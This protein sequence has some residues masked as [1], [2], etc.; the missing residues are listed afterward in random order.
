MVMKF[1]SSSESI[2]DWFLQRFFFFFVFLLSCTSLCSQEASVQATINPIEIMIGEQA[3][4]EVKAM[5]KEG[6][7]SVFPVFKPN[8]EIIPGVEVID[9]KDGGVHNA[10][11]GYVE[12]TVTYTITSFDDTLYYLPPFEVKIGGKAFKSKSLALKV[13][14]LDVDTLH[15]ENFFGPK[16]VQSNPFLWSEWK[17]PFW[18]SVLLLLIMVVCY[19]LYLRLRDNKP[20]I[21]SISFVKRILPHQRAINEIEELRSGHRHSDDNQEELKNYYTKLTEALR[22]YIEERYGFSAMEMT[23]SEIIEQ[24]M[25]SA[26]SKSLDEL[27]HVFQTADLVKFAKYST[28]IN[29]NDANLV[30]ALEFINE[31]KR[32]DVQSV[33]IVQPKYTEEEQKTKK[34]RVILKTIVISLLIASILLLCY[35]LYSLGA[36]ID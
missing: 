19:Y 4:V 1:V 29:E 16:D 32:E 26:D 2:I 28:L 36:L 18:L 17:T 21:K 22:K 7:E 9:S 5:M 11:N 25:K 3:K 34:E 15:P 31:T 6:S 8:Q 23:S 24:L 27:R 30:T 35:I 10:E 12:R 20:I 13:L 14:T 33:E